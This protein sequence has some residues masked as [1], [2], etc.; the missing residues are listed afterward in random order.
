MKM[1]KYNPSYA[2]FIV[3]FLNFLIHSYQ[4]DMTFRKRS[5]DLF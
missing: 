5:D 2:I 1:T 4:H 3:I